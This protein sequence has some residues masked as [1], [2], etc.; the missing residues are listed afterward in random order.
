MYT[1][2]AFLVLLST[3]ALLACSGI[4]SKL[5]SIVPPGDATVATKKAEGPAI[6]RIRARGK[7]TVGIDTGEPAG[8]GTPPMYFTDA[9]GNPDG[10]DYQVAK[11]IASSL[12]VQGVE[13]VHGKYSELPAMLVDKQQFDVLISGYTPDDSAGVTWSD[14]YLEYG[15]CLIVPAKSAIKSTNDLWGKTIGIFDDDAAAANV[16]KLVKGYSGI[17]RME[18]GYWDALKAG[19]FDAFIYD[20]PYTAAELKDWYEANPKSNGA[21]RIAQYNLTSDQ[22][23][24]GVRS[25]E[26]EL[27]A[28]V[29]TAIEAFTESD[30]YGESVRRYLSGGTKVDAPTTA[31]RVYTVQRGDTLSKIAAKELGG[32]DNW[33]K[34]WDANKERFPNPNLIEV[35]DQ[36]VIPS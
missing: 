5:E 34:I 6:D 22:Y 4:G 27:L 33:R 13:V 28:A 17:T 31:G 35:G 8:A 14:G 29:N 36:V 32:A 15:L 21:F 30:A 10:F 24:V 9:A 16:E 12:G 18:D 23:A 1:R 11:A 26:P 3:G 25:T 19:N 7:L 2:S 20:Y